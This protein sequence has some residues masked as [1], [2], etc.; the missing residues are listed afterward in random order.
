MFLV[1]KKKSYLK[2]IFN[3]LINGYFFSLIKIGLKLIVN[4]EYSKTKQKQPLLTV[5]IDKLIQDL[6]IFVKKITIINENIT[7]NV[8]RKHLLIQL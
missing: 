2:L 5:D 6:S 3:S 1:T 8:D 7:I 4:K